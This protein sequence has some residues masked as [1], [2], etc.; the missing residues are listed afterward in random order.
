MLFFPRRSTSISQL[1]NFPVLM[2]MW[3]CWY[4]H[5]GTMSQLSLGSILNAGVNVGRRA[6]VMAMTSHP[7]DQT[8]PVSNKSQ[9]QIMETWRT[10]AQ[11][12]IYIAKHMGQMWTAVGGECASVESV[13]VSKA[14]LGWYMGNT[15]KRMTSPAHMKGVCFVEVRLNIWFFSSFIIEKKHFPNP[16]QLFFFLTGRGACVLGECLCEDGWTGD[17][18]G[19]PTS[20]AICQ[21]PDGLLCSGWGKCVCG[22]CMCEDSQHSGDFCERCPT[23]QHTQKSSWYFINYYSF[24]NTHN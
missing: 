17:G 15:A 12:Q 4:V 3:R 18:C 10:P 9:S 5:W 7:A 23:C 20:T 2:K 16:F 19:C 14:G 11:I 24:N 8:S 22:K 1:V 21:S 13:F 6:A